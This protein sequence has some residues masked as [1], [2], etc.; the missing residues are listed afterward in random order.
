MTGLKRLPLAAA[1]LAVLAIAGCEGGFDLNRGV[2]LPATANVEGDDG[3]P[4]QP[5]F[6]QF[7]DIPIPAGAKMNTDRS[8]ILG[9]RDA[10]IGRLVIVTG[11]NVVSAFDFFKQRAPEF[12]WQ[13]VT[14]VRSAI[15]ILTYTRN[16]RVLTIQ[17]QRRRIGGAEIDLTVS[18]RGQNMPQAIQSDSLQPPAR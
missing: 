11:F 13:E 6:S 15:S 12:G 3:K 9:A 17:I 14:S 7:Q 8:L 5:S 2:A 10:W 4:A 18:P 16:E 1:A